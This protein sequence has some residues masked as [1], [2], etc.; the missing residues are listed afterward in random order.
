[1][2][3]VLALLCAGIIVWS[4]ITSLPISVS[5]ESLY[6]RKIVSVVYDD[7]G[8]MDGDKW[9]YANY[10]MQAF[11][12]MLNSEDQLF[13][14]YMS[15]SQQSANYHPEKVDLSAGGIQNSVDLIMNHSDS[16]ST[17]Y[18]AVEAA[19][20]KLKSINDS[21]PNTQYWLV[22]I[23]DGEFDECNSMSDDEKKRFLNESF[24]GYTDDLM[25]NGTNPQI[26]FMGIGDVVSPD[27][28]PD[29]GIY[30]Y[31]ASN[32][33]EIVGVMSEM[34]DRI[35]GRTRLENEDIK[36]ID[37]R[38]IQVSSSIPLL[39][40]AV[41]VQGTQE[42]ITKV[43]YGNETDIP[44]SRKVSLCYSGYSDL[45]GGAFLLGDSK[46]V[47]G[48]GMY[49]IEFDQDIDL[50]DIIVLFEPALEMRMTVTLNDK[51]LSDFGE[52]D[53]AMEGDKVSVSCKI[54]EMGTDTEIDPALM[55]PGTKFNISV[56]EEGKVVEQSSGK[57]ML[58]HDYI[59][60][61]IDTEITAAL[62]I[63]GFN[64]ID[65]S[66]RFKP[67]NYVPK[68]VYSISADLGGDVKSVK[69]DDIANNR[70]LT[71]CFTVYA[72]GVAITDPDAVKALQPVI[73]I[74]PKGNDGNITYSRDGK[75]VFTPNTAVMNTAN[76][77]NL[78]VDV[79]C[80][81]NDGTSASETYTVLTEDYQVISVDASQAVRKTELFDNHVS[82][83]FYIIKDGVRLNKDCIEK[84]FSVLLNEKHFDLKNDV[85]VSHDG[86]I[87][88]TPY[89]DESHA[90]TFWNWWIN[91][92]Y[93][94]R[95]P[96]DDIV[97]TLN[98]SL[99]NAEAV[100]DIVEEDIGYQL[101]NVYL[102]LVLEVVIVLYFIWWLYAIYAKPKFLPGAVLYIAELSYGGKPG[103]RYHEIDTITEVN[104]KQY[105]SLK[106]RISPT[107]KAKKHYI[108]KNLTISAGYGGSIVCHSEVWYKGDIS[109]K[110]R[111][112]DDLS[113]PQHVKAYIEDHES[114]K[115]Q[116]ISAYD[117]DDIHLE[118][119][120]D[121]PNPELYY[122]HTDMSNISIVDGVQVIDKGTIF[123]YA[124]RLN[125]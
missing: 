107:L 39:N 63:E 102:P 35:S 43:V 55:P 120:I 31:L 22:V 34:A 76:D 122:V 33:D 95:L 60:K 58:L 68:V 105:N 98:H 91:W 97:V 17:P 3:K 64:P 30:T 8:S 84:N 26:T 25:S 50:K 32:A 80:T 96:G 100:I 18:T 85:F 27:K 11:C 81:L 4:V 88:I 7:S 104:L 28:S 108:G 13:I 73:D 101:L 42:K 62:V 54:Y 57:E 61:N 118:E 79:T 89:S 45:V 53:N 21:N 125:N 6:I 113:H 117:G 78:D 94:F 20:D 10:A 99:G 19:Y 44:I 16:G 38:T 40:I 75:I 70:D 111:I 12:G 23:T 14:T 15:H 49:N 74:S 46:N 92:V 59:L 115:I 5:A 36:K 112:R 77:G 29:K 123:A 65:Y 56:S 87:T 72:D 37:D 119:S 86:I 82:V 106:Y 124:I 48:S 1:M 52:L 67:T 69:F 71:V 116:V 121:N 114:L 109:T 47:V 24:G 103:N 66:V 93:Y 2:K 51:E 9:A 41:F 90:L 83:S 110:D